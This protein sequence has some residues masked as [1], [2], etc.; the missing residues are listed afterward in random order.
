MTEISSHGQRIK[1]TITAFLLTFITGIL[2]VLPFVV[3]GSAQET[4]HIN[5]IEIGKIFSYFM[6]GMVIMQFLNGYIIKYVKPKTELLI[7]SVIYLFCIIGMFKVDTASQAPV[8]AIIIIILGLCGGVI[9]TI[10]NYIIVH[11]FQ[12]KQRTTRLNLLDFC[13]SAGSSGYPYIVS[14]LFV[15]NLNWRDIYATVIIV[16]IVIVFML[17]ITKL[18]ELRKS[19]SNEH[20]KYS[21][22]NASVIL[23]GIAIFFFFISYTGFTY[24]LQGCLQNIFTGPYGADKAA[25]YSINA[26]TMFWLFYAIGCV[27]SSVLIHKISVNVYIIISAVVACCSFIWVFHSVNVGAVYL[28]VSILGLGCST[29]YSSSIAYG[30]QLVESASPRMI[31]YFI[32]LSGIGTFSGEYLANIWFNERGYHFVTLAS[33]YAMA[34]VAILYIIVTIMNRGKKIIID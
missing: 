24:I 30:S 23:V 20:I 4:L 31:S 34:M 1:I 22:W 12:G 14:W 8:L 15:M 33:V 27:V 13:F 25:S 11:A 19:A 9:V 7:I 18:P 6:V 21:K 26:I 32:V 29:T 28:A 17:L 16:W 2:V 3:Q 10:P 5:P